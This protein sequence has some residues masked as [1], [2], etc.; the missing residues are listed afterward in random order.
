MAK[1]TGGGGPPAG[2]W[3]KIETSI[4]GWMRALFEEQCQKEPKV[5]TDPLFAYAAGYWQSNQDTLF[6]VDRTGADRS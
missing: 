3:P 6:G 1:K 4:P 2:G 5:A